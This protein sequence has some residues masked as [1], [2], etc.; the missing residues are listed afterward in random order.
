MLMKIHVEFN[1]IAEMVGFSKFAGGDL[2][3]VPL[4]KNQE[5]A[6]KHYKHRYEKL[7]EAYDR[8]EANLE[9]AYERIRMLDPKGATANKN[10]ED[11]IKLEDTN[12]SVVLNARAI[13][14]LKGD[15]VLTLKDLLNKTEGELKWTPGISKVT[16]NH[17]KEALASKG[18]K[19]AKAKQ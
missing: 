2:V 19:L 13:N 6:E 18:Y 17:I 5:Q 8:T 12:C 11:F 14:A 1:S 9:R 3:Q 15:G 10:E 7:K 4:S 16:V